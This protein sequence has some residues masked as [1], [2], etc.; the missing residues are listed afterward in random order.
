M[1]ILNYDSIYD[2]IS[3]NGEGIEYDLDMYTDD[4]V[5]RL[6]EE[7]ESPGRISK[8]VMDIFEETYAGLG[9]GGTIRYEEISQDEYD[10][11][12]SESDM[13]EIVFSRNDRTTYFHYDAPN[14]DITVSLTMIGDHLFIETFVRG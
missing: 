7:F 1:D 14:D 11:I 13:L 8:Q 10:K 6:I 4:E 2:F 9:C 12:R 5:K 3:E